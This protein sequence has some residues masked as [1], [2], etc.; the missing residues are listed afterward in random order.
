MARHKG[1]SGKSTRP[2]V[3]GEKP[4]PGF[5][6]PAPPNETNRDHAA[7]PGSRVPV[8][9]AGVIDP[10]D[11]AGPIE[12]EP[13]HGQ[14]RHFPGHGKGPLN[15]PNATRPGTTWSGISSPPD[16]ATSTST[17]AVTEEATEGGGAPLSVP[18]DSVGPQPPAPG[19]REVADPNYTAAVW[20][21]AHHRNHAIRR[22]IGPE[23]R[24]SDIMSPDP[25][26]CEP[27][28]LVQYVART[29]AER[30]V[31]AVPVVQ[32]M[33]AM[34]PAGIIT[35]RDIV[36]RV[37]AKNQ[38]AGSL[39]ADQCMTD[40]VITIDENATAIEAVMRMRQHHIRRLPVVDTR[41][42]LVGMLSLVDI[43]QP[44]PT[45]ATR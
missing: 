14:H 44:A 21:H 4:K 30:Q 20:E 34:Q 19:V 32:S 40:N 13:D 36:V 42:R 23:T 24:V 28:T 45:D 38:D 26:Y 18:S 10:I 37:V 31:G 5:E 43:A 22:D 9:G 33:D 11:D 35:D 27:D 25:A 15:A 41:G 39:R 29:M 8:P 3:R 16:P 7:P 6:R 12:T 2:I 1:S 17:T